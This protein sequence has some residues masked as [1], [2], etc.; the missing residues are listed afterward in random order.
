MSLHQMTGL[1]P[2]LTEVD[3][4]RLEGYVVLGEPLPLL[5]SAA[6]R[7]RYVS[8]RSKGMR[9]ELTMTGEERASLQRAMA[10][11][12]APETLTQEEQDGHRVAEV[13]MQTCVA[14]DSVVRSLLAQP[15]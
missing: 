5:M 2:H 7:L 3:L 10:R 11:V 9:V 1:T 13:L 8:T 14:A 15:A 6:L 12:E 4:E